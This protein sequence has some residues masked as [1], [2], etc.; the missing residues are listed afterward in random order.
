MSEITG[1]STDLKNLYSFVLCGGVRVEQLE[2]SQ[3]T[4][5]FRTPLQAFEREFG[6]MTVSTLAPVG[7]NNDTL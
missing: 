7:D 3:N 6:R 1:I 2:V 5:S 4:Y